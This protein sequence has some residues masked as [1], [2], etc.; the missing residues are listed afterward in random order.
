M[1]SSLKHSKD[2]RAFSRPP[3]PPTPLYFSSSFNIY[4]SFHVPSFFLRRFGPELPSICRMSERNEADITRKNASTM[5]AVLHVYFKRSPPI[6][7]PDQTSLLL[8]L[9]FLFASSAVSSPLVPPLSLPE[10]PPLN[11]TAHNF[12][13]H[14]H[15]SLSVRCCLVK[16]WRQPQPRRLLLLLRRQ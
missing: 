7:N 2:F 3:T 6:V 10:F 1:I 9:Q 16:Q 12:L 8:V 13:L 14:V 15:L 4:L 11:L 5:Q